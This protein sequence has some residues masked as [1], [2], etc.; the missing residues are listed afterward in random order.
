MPSYLEAMRGRK[1]SLRFIFNFVP[2]SNV[3]VWWE[4]A[5]DGS[6]TEMTGSFP[7]V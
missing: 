4:Y 3:H 6:E 2:G 1:W 5:A 7:W